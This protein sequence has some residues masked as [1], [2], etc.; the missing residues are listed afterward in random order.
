LNIKNPVGHGVKTDG[1]ALETWKSLTDHFNA[2]TDLGLMDAEN[3]LHA[4]KYADGGDLDA[5]FSALHIAWEKVNNQGGQMTDPQFC[6][7]VL[8]SMPKSWNTLVS[9]L[10]STKSSNEVIVQLMLNGQLLAC[11]TPP[12]VTMPSQSTS[13]HTLATQT[14]NRNCQRST[15]V[16][17]NPVCGRT[18][19]TFDRCFKPGG[20][21][22]GQYP[23][24]WE[25][26]GGLN[27]LS[28][29]AAT[30]TATTANSTVVVPPN[31]PTTTP[32]TV[33]S[34]AQFYAFMA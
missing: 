3:R 15:E 14:Q 33:S 23:L 11:D 27:S 32:T 21:M 29:S 5:H 30:N 22:A 25:K 24:W 4:I 8:G 19:H 10:M 16:C 6:M 17:S 34:L 7:I 2:V 12:S 18:G 9:T 13:T 31:P 28:G 1:T 26:H 20:G